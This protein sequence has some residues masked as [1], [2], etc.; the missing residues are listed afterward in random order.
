MKYWHKQNQIALL[1]LAVSLSLS[2]CQNQ[3]TEPAAA[4][5]PAQGCAPSQFDLSDMQAQMMHLTTIP[6]ESRVL[7]VQLN[8]PAVVQANPIMTIPVTSLLP[9]RVEEVLV[10]PGDQVKHGRLLGSLRSDEVGQIESELLTKVMESEAERKQVQVK[11]QLAQKIYERRKVLIDEKIGSRAELEVAENELEQEK[12][13]LRAIEDRHIAHIEAAV[14]RLKLFG[15]ERKEVDRVLKTKEIHYLFEIR[16]PRTGDYNKRRR[17]GEMIEGGKALFEV[18]D[19]SQVYLTA[20]LSEKDISLVK[21][22][23]PVTAT[24]DSYPGKTFSG[25]MTYISSTVEPETR[26]L[27]VK[28][29]FDNSQALLKPEMFGDLTIETAKIRALFL[30][31]KCVQ[32]IGESAVVYVVKHDKTFAETKVETGRTLGEF[33]EIKNGLKSGDVVAEEGSLKLLGMALQRLSK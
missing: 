31:T 12:A 30:P 8:I 2:G 23:M 19:L 6:V 18:A 16:A 27:P 32:Q 3:T 25:T 11:M 13:A 17:S 15:I 14:Q 21:R 10:Q 4:T 33:V 1:A 22:G 20:Q 24:V 26:T 29:T 7:P 9:G 5:L 28:A